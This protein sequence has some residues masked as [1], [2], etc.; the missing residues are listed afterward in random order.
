MEGMIKGKQYSVGQGLQ[1]SKS[2]LK[3]EILFVR[4]ALPRIHTTSTPVLSH[5]RDW[6]KSDN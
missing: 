6:Y 2:S 5:T 3:N 4:P 1:S